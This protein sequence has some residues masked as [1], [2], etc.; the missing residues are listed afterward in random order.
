MVQGTTSVVVFN[1][2]YSSNNKTIMLN[3]QDAEELL[4][5]L[6]LIVIFLSVKIG[7]RLT[8]TRK[9]NEFKITIV[10]N[11]YHYCLNIEALEKV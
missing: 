5:R 9:K 7:K 3:V 4:V 6:Q 10:F 1:L 8:Y 2:M 11:L